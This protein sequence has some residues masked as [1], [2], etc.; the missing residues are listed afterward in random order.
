VIT[1]DE[2]LYDW[3]RRRQHVQA[4]GTS[5]LTMTHV[6]WPSSISLGLESPFAY[7]ASRTL[8]TCPL[9]SIT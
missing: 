6:R 9:S 8:R 4:D 2:T 7:V 1:H 3:S 5:P